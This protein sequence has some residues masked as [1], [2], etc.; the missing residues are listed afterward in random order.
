MFV[1][2]LLPALA[3]LLL[4]LEPSAQTVSL[5]GAQPYV[6]YWDSL[7]TQKR[8]EGLMVNGR[9]WNEWKFWSRDG[10][11]MEKAEFKSGERDGRVVL[12]YDNDSVQHDGFIRRGAQDSTMRSFY[13]SGKLMEEGS[14]RRG[15]KTGPWNYF[16]PDGRP[17]LKEL[18]ED[19]VALALEAWDVDGKATLVKGDG[20]VR[21]Y[22][23][24]GALKEESHYKGGVLS[25]PYEERWPA[26]NPKVKGMNVAGVRIGEWSWWFSSGTLEKKCV[27]VKGNWT[28]RTSCIPKMDRRTPQVSTGQVRRT[29]LGPGTAP[30]VSARSSAPSRRMCSMASG[31]TSTRTVS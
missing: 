5:P 29:A 19:S 22:Y 11:L 31:S 15:V 16:Y 4:T 7:R 8:S 28:V 3:L 24:S 26:G 20:F 2:I 6:D 25:G 21:T 23:P 1:R 13:R 30:A 9:E 18:W 14:Y 12:Y 17:L 27:Y 10:K